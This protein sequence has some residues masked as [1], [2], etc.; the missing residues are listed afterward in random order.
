MFIALEKPDKKKRSDTLVSIGKWMI[1]DHEIEE[2]C[3]L[4]L[5][6]RVEILTIECRDD[7][8]E[9]PFEAGIFLVS[10]KFCR[11][12]LSDESRFE[13][14]DGRYCFIITDDIGDIFLS[15]VCE[16]ARVILVQ[17]HEA[18][19]ITRDDIEKSLCLSFVDMLPF[20]C[21]ELDRLSELIETRLVDRISLYEILFQTSRRPYAECCPSF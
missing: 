3:C 7:A 20:L 11:F 15:C 16:F 19:G 14:S 5:D 6:R 18:L 1:F 8:R 13:F 12:T 10:E 2:M 17:E 9:Y 4:L 21:E